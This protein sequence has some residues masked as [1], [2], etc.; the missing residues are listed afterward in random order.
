MS[1]EV[2]STA[3]LES[4]FQT[5]PALRAQNPLLKTVPSQMLSITHR[6]PLEMTAHI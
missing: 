3:L 6:P 2:D 4:L 1:P 5:S